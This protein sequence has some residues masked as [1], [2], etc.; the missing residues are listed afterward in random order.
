[1]SV[2]HTYSGA[3]VGLKFKAPFTL[4]DLPKHPFAF[5]ASISYT[6]ELAFKGKD[7]HFVVLSRPDYV[8]KGKGFAIEG[9]AGLSVQLTSFLS[10][11]GSYNYY[12]YTL[13]K[14]QYDNYATSAAGPIQGLDSDIKNAKEI[15][16]GPSVSVKLIF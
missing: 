10:V 11:E 9:H 14:G 16:H 8:L 13:N 3:H 6:P 2:K 12:Q 4:P 15:I 5:K 1:F 7:M